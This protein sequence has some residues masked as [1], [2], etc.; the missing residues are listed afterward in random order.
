[1][2]AVFPAAFLQKAYKVK[3][4]VFFNEKCRKTEKGK[5]NKY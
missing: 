4:W 5:Q 1:M 3:R 2:F